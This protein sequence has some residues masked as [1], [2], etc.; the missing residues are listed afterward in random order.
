SITVTDDKGCV[1]TTSTTV[2]QPDMLNPSVSVTNVTCFAGTNGAIDLS[3]SG[4]TQGYTYLWSNP[5]G[6][7]TQDISGLVAGTYTVTITDANLCAATISATVTQ[8]NQLIATCPGNM[9]HC[10]EDG[11]LTLTGAT[12]TG[13]VYS[14][15]GVTGGVFNPVVA[16][17]G[18]HTITYTY[19]N[20]AGCVATC[21]FTIQ[22]Y[23]CCELPE[24]LCKNATVVLAGNTV[25]LLPAQ[26]D[27]GS[28][29]DCGL[30]CLIVTPNVFDCDDIGTH[31]VTLKVQ[32]A[33]GRMA[34][35]TATVT[36]RDLTT[37]SIIC[38]A[39]KVVGTEPGKC[40]AVVT[41]ANP[42]FGDNCPGVTAALTS[43]LPS[44]SMFPIGMTVVEWKTT[45]HVGLTKTCSFKVTVNDVQ[46][47]TITCPPNIVKNTDAGRCD[48]VVTYTT[49][50]VGDNCTGASGA[51]VPP[52]LPSGSVFPKGVNTVV[53]EATDGAG[54]TKRCT[55]TVTVNDNQLPTIT[56]PA[57]LSKSTMLDSCVA[58]VTYGIPTA[59][60]NCSSPA[61]TVT[62]VSGP[63]SGGRFLKGTTTVIW[64]ATDGA[65]LSRT[66]SFMVMVN[67]TQVPTAKCPAPVTRY[68]TSTSC[69]VPV[70][71]AVTLLDN[72]PGGTVSRVSGL[73]SGSS[74]PVGV[75]PVVWKATDASG[76]TST[77]SFSVTVLDTIKPAIS[78]PANIVTGTDPGQCCAME[79]YTTPT[80]SD[81]C[82]GVT[83][84]LHSGLASGSAFPPGVST[85]VWR[86][87]DASGNTRTCSF[88]VTVNDTQPPMVMCPGNRTV[89]GA[90]NPCTYPSASLPSATVMENCPN[91]TLTHNAP[92][93]LGV[94]VHAIVWTATDAAGN[95]AQCTYQVTV[96]CGTAP[97]QSTTVEDRDA[98]Q[99]EPTESMSLL[100]MPNPTQG[101]VTATFQEMKTEEG[102]LLVYDPL[103]RLIV[104]QRL[105][106]GQ[107]QQVLE[108]MG[109]LPAGAYRVQ[110]RTAQGTISKT[111]MV[112]R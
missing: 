21:T 8:P 46:P 59:T 32:D 33:L 87:T 6:S 84:A 73:A 50:T 43:G 67:D 35:C 17:I 48:A 88:T 103:G 2:N 27:N 99:A 94:G 16:G 96:Q 4:G 60:D 20:T 97:E 41:Y 66:C 74:F 58:Y 102:L 72:C 36:V 89:N 81:N 75:S 98:P 39:D 79:T 108:D 57:N 14:G 55:F 23:I 68:S 53:W 3:I 7:T 100:L 78:C 38:P 92:A 26:V 9:T 111:L 104:Q 77:C 29:A 49:P 69:S 47:P 64:R 85:V 56:C 42:S 61:P 70:T 107:T 44:G 112:N 91:Y 37:P 10:Y 101:R 80:A 5:G 40:T 12:P 31:I 62:R 93:Q 65:G 15:P 1:T 76:N 45:D 86:G 83:V 110:L 71:Y 19:I 22:V 51:L 54:L 109:D 25:T 13:G 106:V 105:A 11:L 90:G 95:P 30:V 24:A 52:S 63:A 34:T 18:T 28:T 82:S